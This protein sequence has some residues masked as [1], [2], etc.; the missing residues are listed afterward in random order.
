MP[1]LV[2]GPRPADGTSANGGRRD[3]LLAL[4]EAVKAGDTGALRT[5]LVAIVPSQMR[6]VRRV[7]GPG[8]IDIEDVAYEAAYATVDGLSRFRGEGTV[9]NFACRVAALV[10][11]NVRRADSARKRSATRVGD[12]V[13]TAFEG[14][15]PEES[16]GN[17]SLAPIVR[18]LFG[19]LS[20]PLAQALALHVVLGYTI[21]EIAEA[22]SIPE[23]TVRSR[24]RLGK[25]ALRKRVLSHPI[26]REAVGNEP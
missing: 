9:L 8:R 21:A 23:E 7:L 5:F 22:A 2:P 26:L 17:A 13:D 15:S 4:A 11:M 1:H 19:T 18:E 25:Q 16:A 24:L 6:V 10:A 14:P 20:E 3:E 12:D